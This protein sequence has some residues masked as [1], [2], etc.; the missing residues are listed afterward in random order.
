MNKPI[1]ICVG[2]PTNRGIKPQT[3]QCL[4]RL[5][6][7]SKYPIHAVV[8]REFP[9]VAMNRINIVLEA[10]KN[11]C[12]HILF[13]D[14]DMIF[15]EEVLNDLMIHNKR[16]IGVASYCRMLPLTTT[17]KFFDEEGNM[18]QNRKHPIPTDVFK[19]FAVGMGVALIDIKVFDEI[20]I[21]WFLFETHEGGQ[22]KT[23]E[24]CY[25]CIKAREHGID[26]WCDPNIFIK[27]VGD[28]E[29]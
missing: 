26:V 2:I 10:Q 23:G 20:P 7:K 12:T 15:N 24:D 9:T 17:V 21:P 8:E 1:K 27:H 11:D 4:L 19:A 25:F 18:S 3:A 28:Y 29:Y 13:I 6:A 14:D 16:I 5:V 22:I